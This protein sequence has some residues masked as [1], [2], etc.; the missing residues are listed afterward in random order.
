M[1]DLNAV[2]AMTGQ[3]VRA[4]KQEDWRRVTALE[5]NRQGLIA[6]VFASP[7]PPADAAAVGAVISRI[8][9][10]NQDLLS[11]GSRGRDQLAGALDN[12][13]KGRRARSAYAGA[14]GK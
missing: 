10:L 7:V 4:A 3:M 8:H 5:S 12:M 11:M 13:A 2:L 14:S 9:A 1:R 6:A